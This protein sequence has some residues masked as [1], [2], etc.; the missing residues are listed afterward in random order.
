MR[1]SWACNSSRLAT[2]YSGSVRC[3]RTGEGRG[4]TQEERHRGGEKRWKDRA[5]DKSRRNTVKEGA[6][7]SPALRSHR[8]GC[9][10]DRGAAPPP[11]PRVTLCPSMG[12]W[13]DGWGARVL[14]AES[15]ECPAQSWAGGG[16]RS[17]G[18]SILLPSGWWVLG[19]LDVTALLLKSTSG[20]GA[21]L[22][23]SSHRFASRS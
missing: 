16:Q 4:A 10:A 7:A 14:G 18:T 15:H 3:S 8:C 19:E 17:G 21:A 20:D 6:S 9:H 23:R 11:S 22:E 12:G 13:V 5:V 1:L 2:S